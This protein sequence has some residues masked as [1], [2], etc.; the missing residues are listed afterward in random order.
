[1]SGPEEWLPTTEPGLTASFT[2]FGSTIHGFKG[3]FSFP[4]DFGGLSPAG[5]ASIGCNCLIFKHNYLMR[6]F[7]YAQYPIVFID[8]LPQEKTVKTG[9]NK[10]L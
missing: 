10:L 4:G 6:Y 9:V 1:M 3:D 5:D 7:Q 8:L 2:F